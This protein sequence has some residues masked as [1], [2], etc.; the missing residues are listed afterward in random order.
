M[1]SYVIQIVFDDRDTPV[2]V[3]LPELTL[4]QAEEF[5]AQLRHDVIEAKSVNAPVIEEIQ[6]AIGGVDL[7]LDPRRVISIDLQTADPGTSEQTLVE[8]GEGPVEL[9]GPLDPA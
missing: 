4:D 3:D 5:T 2:I 6:A 1:S 7:V 9:D 8:P